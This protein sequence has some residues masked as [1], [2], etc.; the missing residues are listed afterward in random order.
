[1]YTMD[2]VIEYLRF[3]EELAR[4]NGSIMLDDHTLDTSNKAYVNEIVSNKINE[5]IRNKID[6][7]YRDHSFF[8][9][10][11]HS[12]D[13]YEW[14]CD[15]LD[16]AFM[17]SIGHKVSVTSVTL[18]LCGK[19][20]VSAVYDPWNDLMYSASLGGGSKMN[21][22][23]I[24]A[25]KTSPLQ[26][27]AVINSEWWPDA[28][29]DVEMAVHQIAASTG[30]Y[31]VHLGSVIHSACLVAKGVFNASL[32]GGHITEEKNREIAAAKLIVEEAGGN[33]TDL[34]GSEINFTGSTRGFIVSGSPSASHEIASRINQ[35]L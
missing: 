15:P 8:Q 7:R 17:Y 35:Y 19:S 18:T 22:R 9:K 34:F 30:A 11:R 13:G 32:F 33:I 23:P 25:K 27:Y 29:Y 1:M 2:N 12:S 21:G 6:S 14:I 16:G 20:I 24:F 10:N 28:E 5:N 31:P 4:D 26:K 3:A